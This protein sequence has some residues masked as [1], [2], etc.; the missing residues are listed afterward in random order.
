MLHN[1]NIILITEIQSLLK[2]NL[3]MLTM[4]IKYLSTTM[5]LFIM[6]L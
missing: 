6:Y 5:S 4:T 1:M 2:R 3:K